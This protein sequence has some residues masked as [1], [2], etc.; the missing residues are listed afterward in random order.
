MNF[1]AEC[2]AP[3]KCR[4]F[5][6]PH[7]SDYRNYLARPTRT[8]PVTKEQLVTIRKYGQCEYAAVVRAKVDASKAEDLAKAASADVSM[9]EGTDFGV[10]NSEE[11]I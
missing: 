11:E 9:K 2:K 8:R 10:L 1:V 4:N 6:G 7:R 3:T 5:V